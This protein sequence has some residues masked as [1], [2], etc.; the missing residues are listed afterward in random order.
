MQ[1]FTD[2]GT[3]IIRIALKFIFVREPARTSL[4]VLI[5][6]LLQAIIILLNPLLSQ[7]N[8]VD[9]ASLSIFQ[10]IIFGIILVYFPLIISF[11]FSKKSQ[12]NDESVEMLLR[13][14]DRIKEDG[15]LTDEQVQYLYLKVIEKVVE[16]TQLKQEIQKELNEINQNI[17]QELLEGETKQQLPHRKTS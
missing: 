8:I 13:T 1:N 4:G 6:V 5:G 7:Y 17:A 11:T 9:F 10:Y 3:R 15:K 2:I 12:I 16:K 14:I